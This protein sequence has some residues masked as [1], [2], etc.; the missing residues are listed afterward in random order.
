[1]TKVLF[2]KEKEKRTKLQTKI[3]FY[4][5][6]IYHELCIVVCRRKK[7]EYTIIDRLLQ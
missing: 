7:N 3:K 1:M 4:L 6:F 2:K 5:G